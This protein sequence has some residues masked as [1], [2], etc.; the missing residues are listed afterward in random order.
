MPD[1]QPPASAAQRVFVCLF[2]CE[3]AFVCQSL[4]ENVF[5]S[6]CVCVYMMVVCLRGRG[7]NRSHFCPRKKKKKYCVYIAVTA[8][9]DA[10]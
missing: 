9:S 2:V 5:L 4:C 8:K 10:G 3:R 1:H 7:S 6:L